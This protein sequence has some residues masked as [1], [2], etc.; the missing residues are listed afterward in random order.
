MKLLKYLFPLLL[1][2]SPLKSANLEYIVTDSLTN[3]LNNSTIVLTGINDPNYFEV[4]QTGESNKVSFNVADNQFFNYF[5]NKLGYESESSVVYSDKDKTIESKLKKL[6][7]SSWYDYYLNNGDLEM[8]F[9]SFDEDIYYSG[10]EPFNYEIQFTNIGNKIV[11][12]DQNG[13]FSFAKDSLG[14]Q[15]TGWAEQN[16]ELF[17][18]LNLKEKKGWFKACVEGNEVT[19]YIGEAS[20]K[21]DGRNFDITGENEYVSTKIQTNDNVVPNYLNGKYNIEVGLN[22]NENKSISLSSQD[23]FIENFI[24]D[25]TI[26]DTTITDPDTTIIDPDTTI[27]DP[28]TTFTG[29]DNPFSINHRKGLNKLLHYPNPSNSSFKVKYFKESELR[30]YDLLGREVYKKVGK[31][32]DIKLNTGIYFG[33]IDGNKFKQVILK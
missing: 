24:P 7:E 5:V 21:L 10:G 12:F 28:D 4:K 25:T 8:S 33:L 19:I 16:P 1:A 27:I 2:I 3:P 22:Y 31:D 6:S 29:I 30:I 9:L 32:F 17:Y 11:S 18:D 14:N 20:G 26:I 15:V 23:F 13:L